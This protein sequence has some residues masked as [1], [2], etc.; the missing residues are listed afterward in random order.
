MRNEDEEAEDEEEDFGA[1]QAST[2]YNSPIDE[3]EE[4]CE[5]DRED[6][7]EDTRLSDEK[8]TKEEAL[9]R[10]EGQLSLSDFSDSDNN[11]DYDDKT[12]AENNT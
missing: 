4:G 11:D 8:N 5:Y 2:E 7:R 3:Y 9:S 6:D 12:G 1:T 10:H